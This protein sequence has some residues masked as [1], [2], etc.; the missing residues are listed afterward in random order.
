MRPAAPILLSLLL[1]GA[2]LWAKPR[3]EPPLLLGGVRGQPRAS[4]PVDP[5]LPTGAPVGGAPRPEPAGPR[6]C[7]WNRPVCAHGQPVELA[8][9]ALVALE[10]AYESTVLAL[11]LPPPLADAGRGGTDALDAYLVDARQGLRIEPDSAPFSPFTRAPAYCQLPAADEALLRRAATQCVGEAI[12]LALDA[13]EPPHVR[14]AFATSL[15]WAIG[16]PTSLDLEAIDD[17]QSR[18][19]AAIATLDLSPESEGAALFFAYLEATRSAAEPGHLS[20]A[21][22]SA[23]ASSPSGGGLVYRNE[24]DLFDVLRHSLEEDPARMGALMVDFSVARAFLGQ[25]EDGEHLP[26]LAWAGSFGRARFSWMIPF[27]SLP[28][29]VAVQPPLDSTGSALLWVE[30][31]EVPLGAALAIRAEWEA[32]VT[33]QWQLVKLAASGAELGRIDFPFQERG[34]LAE[35]RVTELEGAAAVLVVGTNLE[36]IELAHPFDPDVAPFEPHGATIYLARL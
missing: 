33:F 4:I 32:P 34:S 21:L 12:A 7:S 10:W 22:F 30:L 16:L 6:L 31:D 35:A 19:E 11:G 20:A 36:G 8:R 25:R 18:P 9:S 5:R 17:A 24:P 2:T 14:R 3:R 28:R 13:S 26:E 15:W 1:S 27:S 23:S 29:R